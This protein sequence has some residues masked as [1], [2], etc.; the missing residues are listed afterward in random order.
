MLVVDA[1]G[2]CAAWE[3]KQCTVRTQVGK[4]LY[5]NAFPVWKG[6]GLG[7]EREKPTG[8]TRGATI[9]TG[10]SGEPIFW[11][12]HLSDDIVIGS[13]ATRQHDNVILGILEP[14]GLVHEVV[15]GLYDKCC[16]M[17]LGNPSIIVVWSIIG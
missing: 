5:R 10:Y 2:E 12:K 9:F 17:S 15:L 3:T 11:S 16:S 14:N 13:S 4:E 7:R 1:I 8:I 6:F